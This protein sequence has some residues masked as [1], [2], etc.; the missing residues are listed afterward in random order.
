M[1]TT[2]DNTKP[3]EINHFQRGIDYISNEHTIM[4]DNRE[5]KYRADE[6]FLFLSGIMSKIKSTNDD[7]SKIKFFSSGVPLN[8]IIANKIL[9]KIYCLAT[10]HNFKGITFSM[11]PNLSPFITYLDTEFRETRVQEKREE[12]PQIIEITSDEEKDPKLDNTNRKRKHSENFSTNTSLFKHK[13]S[14]EEL[15]KKNEVAQKKP[16]H[17]K[18]Q[19]SQPIEYIFHLISTH[20][21]QKYYQK[22]ETPDS[23]DEIKEVLKHSF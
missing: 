12:V 2:I 21:I 6:D 18:P 19:A 20:K 16:K 22:I 23:D 1:F 14:S 8:K 3:L 15:N 10:Q 9:Q 11:I 13:Q 5:S 4:L 17:N 7:D